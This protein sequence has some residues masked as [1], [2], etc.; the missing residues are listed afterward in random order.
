MSRLFRSSDLGV[1]KSTRWDNVEGKSGDPIGTRYVVTLH[2]V[3]IAYPTRSLP[4]LSRCTVRSVLLFTGSNSGRVLSNP[5][6][7]PV[8]HH[9]NTITTRPGRPLHTSCLEGT[10]WNLYRD[11][12][13]WAL[14]WCGSRCRGTPFNEVKA[15]PGRHR[16]PE[17]NSHSLTDLSGG[18]RVVDQVLF[19]LRYLLVNTE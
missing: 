17:F 8:R 2:Q 14:H 18:V 16:F 10:L 11:L 3:V 9:P 12:S 6:S 19:V 5:T 13:T 1:D 15:L 7:P 4:S